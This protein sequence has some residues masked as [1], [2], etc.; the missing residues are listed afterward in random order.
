VVGLEIEDNAVRR[1]ASAENDFSI[2][3]IGVYRMNP[4]PAGFEKE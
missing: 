4:V 1:P 2:R 3:P